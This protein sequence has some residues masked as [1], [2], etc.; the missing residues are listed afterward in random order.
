MKSEQDRDERDRD[1]VRQKLQKSL[2]KLSGDAAK[3]VEEL[4]GARETPPVPI[5]KSG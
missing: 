4:P 3:P 2:E 5:T 1:E